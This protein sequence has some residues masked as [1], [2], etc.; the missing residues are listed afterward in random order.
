MDKTKVLTF[1]GIVLVSGLI[2]G[3]GLGAVMSSQDDGNDGDTSGIKNATLNVGDVAPDFRLADHNV[4]IA[5]F[6]AAFTPV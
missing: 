6:P 4:V 5:F 3:F 2:A 1:L